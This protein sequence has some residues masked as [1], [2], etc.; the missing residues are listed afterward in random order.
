MQFFYSENIDN[1]FIILEGEEMNHC[2]KSLRKKVGD[3]ICVVDGSGGYYTCK[4]INI[5]FKICKLL[6]INKKIIDKKNKVHLFISPTKNH[7]RIEWMLEKIVEIG[8]DRITFLICENS[9]RKTVNL[10]RLNK[11]ALSAM[12]QTQNY[13]L[14]IIDDCLSFKDAFDII[15]SKAKYIAHLCYDNIP[16]LSKSINNNN[17]RCIFI[18]PEG[19]FT[20]NEVSYALKHNFIEVSLGKSRLRTETSGIVSTIILNLDNE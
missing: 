1:D 15:E 2:T 11:I 17:A 12:K 3:L 5:D 7:K 14:P 9:I 6:I 19:D 13:F 4:I 16:L 20:N 10:I 8:V 18:G